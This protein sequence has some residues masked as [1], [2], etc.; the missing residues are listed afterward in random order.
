MTTMSP[1]PAATINPSTDPL[2]LID[3]DHVRFYVGNA[4]QSAFFY[5]SAFGFQVE[6]IRDLTT[7]SRESA[8]YLL[9]QG[10]IRF[11]LETPL[12]K[13]HPASAELAK[14]GDGIKDIAFNVFDAEA[15]WN[16]AVKNGGESAYEPVTASD[17][18]GTVTTAGIKTYGRAVHTFVSRTGEYALPKIKQGAT[19]MPGFRSIGPFALNEYNKQHPCGLKFVDHAVGNVEEGKMN[20]WV[21]FYARVM[22]FA[23][24]VSLRVKTPV[25][26]KMMLPTDRGTTCVHA[27]KFS[28]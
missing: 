5:A 18:H 22:G 20:T 17:A 16:A 11:I 2:Q 13:N 24:L 26:Q 3:V 19:F 28:Y 6:Q 4:K 27:E 12:S 21:D 1:S 9:T 10:N 25:V 8:Q 7:G 15:A 14:F 23:Q